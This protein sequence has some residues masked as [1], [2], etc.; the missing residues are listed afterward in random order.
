MTQPIINSNHNISMQ[1]TVEKTTPLETLED[2]AHQAIRKHFK[3][4]VRYE[5]DVLQDKD[6]ECLHQMRVGM[7]RLRTALQVFGFA[8]KLPK[9]MRD[10]R[11][12]KIAR[13][14]GAVRDLDVLEAEL[15]T[16]QQA[17][18]P[19]GEQEKLET[20]LKKMHKQR[21]QD[22]DSLK[23][24]LKGNQYQ[25]L[26]AAFEEWLDQPRYQPV[27]QMP[28]LEALPDL[29]LPLTS[30]MLLH[31]AWLVGATFE[32][33]KA[34]VHT[35]HP[36]AIGEFLKQHSLVLHDLR[37]QMKRVRYQTELFVDFYDEDYAQ[38]VEEFKMLQEVLG[39]LQDSAVLQ[40]YLANQLEVSLEETC[41]TLARQLDQKV[42]QA[43]E[44]W[45]ALQKRYLNA[46]FRVGLRLLCSAPQS[47]SQQGSEI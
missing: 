11:V 4:S 46:E 29:L 10:R 28:I 13:T 7:R 5:A 17:D 39:H 47:Q 35:I 9:E 27:A 14:L 3:K 20:L 23:R 44:Q 18:L 38:Q 40:E 37:K 43:W 34:T 26:K 21:K 19:L 12:A 32:T 6:P 31:P 33:G 25:H 1:T 15:K 36:E 30:E 24:A 16:Q 8:T 41:P 42:V 22:F 2:F 45:Q